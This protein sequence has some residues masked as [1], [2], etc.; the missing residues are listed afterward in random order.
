MSIVSSYGVMHFNCIV[1]CLPCIYKWL[2]FYNLV[3]VKCMNEKTYLSLSWTIMPFSY[4]T[5][6]RYF[7]LFT[8]SCSLCTRNMQKDSHMCIRTRSRGYLALNQIP[9]PAQRAIVVSYD[10]ELNMP[11]SG[12]CENGAVSAQKCPLSHSL[13]EPAAPLEH[14]WHTNASV[15]RQRLAGGQARE[16]SCWLPTKIYNGHIAEEVEEHLPSA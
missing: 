6:H 7:R 2:L 16:R 11:S 8:L 13:K 12:M 5:I 14:D 1:V 15:L 10:N 9:D 4:I 3:Y